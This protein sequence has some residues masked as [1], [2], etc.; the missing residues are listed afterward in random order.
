MV[1]TTIGM[2]SIL[3]SNM[4]IHK[5]LWDALEEDERKI[6]KF[7]E[8]CMRIQATTKPSRRT[9]KD[10]VIEGKTV[11]AG[12]VL[13]LHLQS[14][15]LDTEQFDDPMVF[16]I[17]R[18]SKKNLA[19]GAGNHICI[20][21]GMAKT[22]GREVLQCILSERR[23]FVLFHPGRTKYHPVSP[24]SDQFLSLEVDRKQPWRGGEYVV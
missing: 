4:L 15:N 7:L 9:T 20:G 17:D 12:S 3:F 18:P 11:P 6:A 13:L 14:A 21:M 23:S 8:E 10:V 19:F 1:E 2:V 5:E 16:R 22:I 24:F